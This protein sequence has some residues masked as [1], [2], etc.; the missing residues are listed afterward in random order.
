MPP[1]IPGNPHQVYARAGWLGYG[2]W[3][4]TGTVANRLKVFRSFVSARA[5]A[6]SL[7]LGSTD[8]WREFAKNGRLPVD[9][10]KDPYGVYWSDKRWKGM[11]DWLGTGAVSSR[12]KNFRPFGA[13]RRYVRTLGLASSTGWGQYSSSGRRPN[14]IPSAPHSV[15]RGS[16]WAGWPDWLGFDPKER[17]R[18]R[19]W[20][21][22]P[23]ARRLARSLK[24][25][26]VKDWR[27]Y[28]S[29]RPS[30]IPANPD[31]LYRRDGWRGWGDWLGANRRQ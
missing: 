16:G 6:R 10:P 17:R 19:H 21:P 2:D 9:I 7:G 28:A 14:D 12:N 3:L 4:G 24:L 11:G 5:F 26:S 27:A 23:A 15:Y 8:E 29:R 13:A 20:R 25:T 30:D 22:F 18:R 31:Q 1:D